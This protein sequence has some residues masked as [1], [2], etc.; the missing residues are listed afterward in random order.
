MTLLPEKYAADLGAK[1]ENLNLLAHELA[2]Q[3]YGIKIVAKDW[4]DFWLSEGMA[5]FLAD[6]YVE[7]RFGK[8][9]YDRE[10]ADSKGIYEGL[11]SQGKDRPLFFTDWQTPQQAGGP[12][13][14][15]TSGA[16]FP[17]AITRD[18]DRPGVLAR[19]A[20]I[21]RGAVGQRGNQRRF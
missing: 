7:R 17:G 18:A 11:R 8:A 15:H 2:H 10:I 4:S 21:Y 1:P 12:L 20:T 16:Y 6:T 13:P 19:L 14:Y 3:W 9:R 5:T